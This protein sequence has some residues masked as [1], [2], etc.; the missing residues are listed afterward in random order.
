M[1]DEIGNPTCTSRDLDIVS[2]SLYKKS[3]S[4]DRT[5]VFGPLSVEERKQTKKLAM[6]PKSKAPSR[7]SFRSTGLLLRSFTLASVAEA[8][9][10]AFPY[11][12]LYDTCV[13]VQAKVGGR[14]QPFLED[15]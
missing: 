8:G 5:T 12:K 13:R 10:L 1:C 3:V 11:F 15:K 7:V 6:W 9:E 4:G 14:A 2:V